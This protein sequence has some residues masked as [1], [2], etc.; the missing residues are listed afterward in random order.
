M[1]SDKQKDCFK[2]RVNFNDEDLKDYI[3]NNRKVTKYPD[4]STKVHGSGPVGPVYYDKYG[5]EC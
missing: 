2:S 3:E 1:Y 4:G 5:N